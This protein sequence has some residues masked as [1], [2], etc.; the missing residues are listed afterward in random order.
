MMRPPRPSPVWPLLLTALSGLAS[1]SNEGAQSAPRQT[2]GA[3]ATA[4]VSESIAEG[5]VHG[6]IAGAE[7][8]LSNARFQV[9]HV[10][11]RERVDIIFDTAPVDLCGLPS[12]PEDRGTHRVWLRFTG[13]TSLE[14]GETRVRARGDAG[15]TRAHYER[16]TEDGLWRGSGQAE[17]LVVID[18]TTQ[19]AVEGRL[20]AC[21]DDGLGSCVQGRFRATECA[22]PLDISM[23]GERFVGEL[24][25]RER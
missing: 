9:R 21:F 4:F 15:T 6:A 19:D 17:A 20:Q 7:V 10:P 25:R 13:Q 22:S 8:I 18:S 2:F 14:A 12:S 24:E 1:C 5:P 11:G 3:D 23:L 16:R